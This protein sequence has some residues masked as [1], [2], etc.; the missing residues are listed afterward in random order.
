MTKSKLREWRR[1]S[2]LWQTE[3]QSRKRNNGSGRNSIR[4]RMFNTDKVGQSFNPIECTWECNEKINMPV[5]ALQCLLPFPRW[6]KRRR[7]EDVALTSIEHLFPW[8]KQTWDTSYI[9]TYIYTHGLARSPLRKFTEENLKF[10]KKEREN[11]RNI[12]FP[13]DNWLLRS[14]SWGQTPKLY[15]RRQHWGQSGVKM[16]KPHFFYCLK[17]L[18]NNC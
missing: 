3:I 14:M 13:L 9:Y 15:F 12:F 6:D 4:N 11:M 5:P 18:H 1:Q 8:K 16:S 17:K 2:E 7:Q 10:S